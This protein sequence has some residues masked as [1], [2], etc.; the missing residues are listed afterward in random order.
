MVWCALIPNVIALPGD[1]PPLAKLTGQMPDISFALRFLWWEP[2]YFTKY[3]S[4]FPSNEKE[5]LGF[6][7][8]LAE[9]V[10]H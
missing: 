1:I 10:G 5:C 8:G 3:D 2:V 7:A 6:F 4:G 9:N